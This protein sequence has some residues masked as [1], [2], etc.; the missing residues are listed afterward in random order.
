LSEG[1]KDAAAVMCGS[2][3]EVYLRNLCAKSSVDS[4]EPGGKPKKASKINDDLAKAK[5]YTVLEQKQVTSWLGLR[6]S[7]AH[8]E[9]DTYDA[10][11]VNL[12]IQG[13]R[14]F[15]TRSAA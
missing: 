9:Y 10:G 13:V 3:L 8:G 11:Q 5:A 1:Y 6:N 4:A 7:A 14:V 12:M 2:V 15:T